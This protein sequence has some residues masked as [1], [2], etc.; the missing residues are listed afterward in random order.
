M[1]QQLPQNHHQGQYTTYTHNGSINKQWNNS[2]TIT[3]QD[4]THPTHTMGAAIN[5][6][7]TTTQSSPRTIHNLHTQLGSNKQWNN[8][9]TITAQD[10]IQ[11]THTMG[12]SNKQSNKNNKQ[13]PPRTINN[14]HSMGAAIN[15][16]ATTTQSQPGTIHNL[17][18]QWG[19]Q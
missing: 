13:S 19:Q 7:T 14:L 1:K 8:S 16:E 11:P 10:N 5:S 6:E 4:N 12:G 18:T 3:A 9:N 2:N 17:H 15:S